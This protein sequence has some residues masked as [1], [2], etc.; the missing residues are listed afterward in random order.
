MPGMT[1][2]LN[3]T[4]LPKHATFEI[5]PDEIAAKN[6]ALSG[7]LTVDHWA[8]VSN[9]LIGFPIIDMADWDA[10]RAIYNT[11]ITTGNMTRLRVT[12]DNVNLDV[13]VY[14]NPPKRNIR[15]SGQVVDGFSITLEAENADS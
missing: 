7:K 13:Q 8:D 4:T 10:M 14:M 15:W 2:Q 5:E 12:S 11:Q 1:I 3:D 9:Y 6:R